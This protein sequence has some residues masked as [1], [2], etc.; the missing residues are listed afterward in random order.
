M[1]GSE[2]NL[3]LELINQTGGIPLSVVSTNT[4]NWSQYI[5]S[6]IVTLFSSFIVFMIVGE[7]LIQ[8]YK[9][10]RVTKKF[11]KIYKGSGRHY[12]ILK[13]GAPKG[14]FDSRGV[15]IDRDMHTKVAIKLQ[16]FKGEPVDIYLHTPGGE[17][18]ATQAIS[19]LIQNYPGETRA[20]IPLFAMSGGTFLTLSCD[21]IFMSNTSCLGPIDPQLGN[22]FKYGSAKA[23]K[24][25]VKMKGKKA[26]DS[27]ISFS[28]MGAQYTKTM[29]KNIDKLLLNK[30]PDNKKRKSVVKLLTD[31]SIEHAYPLTKQDLREVGLDVKDFYPGMKVAGE[32][33]IKNNTVGV[34][35]K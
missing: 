2:I 25:I 5:I 31:G 3:L 14:L 22:L 8:K 15:M 20:I 35:G 10:K 24:E 7:P 29:A 13:N 16:E 4:S 9:E 30:I 33:L 23:W 17:I 26:E 21:K 12:L 28:M 1:N 11:N 19:R 32:L 27:S 6:V 18:F 34:Y